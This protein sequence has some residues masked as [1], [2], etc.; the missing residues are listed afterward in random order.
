MA[1]AALSLLLVAGPA[2]AAL[3]ED[4]ETTKVS[5]N[6]DWRGLDEE[7]HPVAPGTSDSGWSGMAQEIHPVAPGTKVDSSWQ[8]LDQE[9]HPV[10]P[11]TA[12][13]DSSESAPSRDGSSDVP[14]FALVL[15]IG[16]ATLIAVT[17]AAYRRRPRPVPAG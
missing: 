7:L 14:V 15:G 13:A 3:A 11:G 16:L 4:R 9:M 5:S 8:G 12:Q 2:S 6:A 10:A 1:V 17:A